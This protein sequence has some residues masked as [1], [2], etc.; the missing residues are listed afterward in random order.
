[1]GNQGRV[2]IEFNLNDANLPFALD[3][4]RYDWRGGVGE[5]DI[6]DEVPEGTN[7]NDNPRAT[8]EFGSYRGHDRVINWQEIYIGPS[9]P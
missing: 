3:F 7:Y 9:G 5:A 6:F 1:M 4:L 8:V 2:R